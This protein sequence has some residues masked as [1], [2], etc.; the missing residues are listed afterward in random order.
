[1]VLFSTPPK[2]PPTVT[3][4]A[5]VAEQRGGFAVRLSGARATH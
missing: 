2:R 3:K 5:R 4:K 1:M